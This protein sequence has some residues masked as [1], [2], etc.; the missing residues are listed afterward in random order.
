MLKKSAKVFHFHRQ[1]APW[2]FYYSAHPEWD[3]NFEPTI[4]SYWHQIHQQVLQ[5][6]NAGL[7]LLN[8]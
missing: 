2:N 3:Q 7:K 8:F 5:L 6:L 4:F 1:T